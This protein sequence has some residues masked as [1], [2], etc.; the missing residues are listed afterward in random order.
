LKKKILFYR[1]TPGIGDVVM[2][3]RAIE[4][5]RLKHPDAE[6]VVQTRYNELLKYHPAIDYYASLNTIVENIDVR[7]DNSF[8]CAEYEAKNLL[9]K[10]RHQ[11]F[12]ENTAKILNEHGLEPI[13]YDGK[14]QSLYISIELYDW[15]QQIIK[16]VLSCDTIP[17]GIFGKSKEH[18]KT[19]PHIRNLIKLLLADKRFKLF[20]FDDK[21]YLDIWNVSQFVGYDLDMVAALVSQMAL[22][23]SPD[24]AGVHIAGGFNIP[25][26]GIFGPTNPLL[27]IGHYHNAFWIPVKCLYHPCGYNYCSELRCLHS[28]NPQQIY[29][30]I[31]KMLSTIPP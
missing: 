30:A 17:I 3:I 15:A 26:F 13:E 5:T 24:S 23:I 18:W 1:E 4:L 7:I 22:V 8:Y 25:V 21:E 20:Y 16:N 29:K 6:I 31:K 12:C 2:M 11:L 9:S 19:Y 14:P 27:L 10:S 28:L